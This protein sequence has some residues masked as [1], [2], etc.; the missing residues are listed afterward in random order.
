MS[1]LKL[2]TIFQ[3][4]TRV[5]SDVTGVKVVYGVNIGTG[6]GNQTV[7]RP[8]SDEL[9]DE[10]AIFLVPGAWNVIPGGGH[11]RFT[12]TAQ[13]SIWV[14]RADPEAGSVALMEIFGDLYDA[15]VARSKAYQPDP[16]L[17]SVLLTEGE[18]MSDAEWPVDSNTWHLTWPFALEVKVNV[19]AIYQ[20]Q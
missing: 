8:I 14:P 16:T 1:Q 20:A 11:G 19:A 5:C 10:P 13:G 3:A 9:A 6:G 2:P 15:F 18:G 4:L 12:L 17:Q 7:I